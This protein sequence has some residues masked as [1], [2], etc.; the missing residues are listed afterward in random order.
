[1]KKAFTILAAFAA[2]LPALAQNLNPEVQVTGDYNARMAEVSKNSTRM[3]VPDSLYKFD[4]KFDYSVF[5]SPYR[6]SYEFSPYAIQITPS[7]AREVPEKLYVSAGFG[8][9]PHPELEAV[10]TPICKPDFMLTVFNDGKGYWGPYRSIDRHYAV[11]GEPSW[12]GYDLRDNLGVEG[13]LATSFS[14]IL[15][16]AGIDGIFTG[17][18]YKADSYLSAYAGGRMASKASSSAVIKYDAGLKYRFGYDMPGTVND[19]RSHNVVLDASVGPDIVDGYRFLVDFLM[20]ADVCSGMLDEA[21]LRAALT[22]HFDFELGPVEMSAGAALAYSDHTSIYPVV[23]ASI[24]VFKE[25]LTIYADVFGGEKFNTYHDFKLLN[26]RF[27]PSYCGLDIT[28]ERLNA[29]IGFRGHLLNAF[30]YDLKFGYDMLENSPLYRANTLHQEMFGYTDFNM[31]YTD[32]SLAWTSD[33]FEADGNLAVRVTNLPDASECFDLPVLAAGVHGL[34]NWSRRVFAGATLEYSAG[35]SAW[36][37]MEETRVDL[38]PWVNLG[39]EGRYAFNDRWTAWLKVGNLL[40][41]DI[42]R[43]PLYSEKGLNFTAGVALSL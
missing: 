2:C 29:G 26:H 17:D 36:L 16:S 1:M 30:Q 18:E 3:A 4:Y 38:G 33:R 15:F 37:A 41:Q 8:F 39:L 12:W 28:R 24:T 13:R 11:T 6:G 42:R 23:N 35:T 7:S 32:L 9:T 5:E 10:Y 34:Y 40:D 21:R 43:S 22:P 27:D 25:Y 14:D 19:I 20:E 31:F